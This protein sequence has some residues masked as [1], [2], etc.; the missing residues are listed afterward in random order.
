MTNGDRPELFWLSG[1]PPAWRVQL[2][3]EVKGVPYESRLLD[4]GKGD[5]R[6]PEFLALNPRGKVPTLR[7]GATVLG[8]SIAIMAY[9]DRKF[10][11]PPLF[12]ASAEETGRIWRAISECISYTEPAV[13]AVNAPAFSGAEQ[14]PEGWAEK[15][16]TV[17]TE[18]AG[19]EQKL[20]G[21]DWLATPAIS[22]A[23]LATY[24]TVRILLRGVQR[25][26]PGLDYG[27]TPLAG[28]YPNLARW[29]ARIEALP[30]YDRTFPPHWRK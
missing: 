23:D 24:P 26:K 14:P 22:A 28:K 27:L 13:N 4:A 6:K 7:H 18:L 9:L 21:R 10:P 17:Q 16:Q 12:G 3:L 29:M 2:V 11:A 20:Q 19:L 8:E 25:A 15:L 1:S 5:L 30:N